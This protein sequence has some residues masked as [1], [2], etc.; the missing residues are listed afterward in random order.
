MTEPVKPKRD[1]LAWLAIV[2]VFAASIAFGVIAVEIGRASCR[3]RV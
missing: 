2:V 1:R 3:E